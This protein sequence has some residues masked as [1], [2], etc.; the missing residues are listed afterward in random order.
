MKRTILL[1]LLLVGATSMAQERSHRGHHGNM[2]DLTPEQMATLQT[3]K[4]T[5]ALDLSKGQQNQILALNL[6]NSK[7]RK[8][9][10]EEFKAKKKEDGERKKPTSEERFTMQNARLDHQIA[11]KTKMKEI[12]SPEQME[13]WEKMHHRKRKHHFGKKKRQAKRK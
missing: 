2:H 10:I 9:K 12:L 13:K 8:S 4:M 1:M 3:K 7:L 11:Q 6:E 5:L